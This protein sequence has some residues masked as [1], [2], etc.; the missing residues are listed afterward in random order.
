MNENE[1]NSLQNEIN[2]IKDTLNLVIK[3]IEK[4]TVTC[5]RMDEHIS[6]VESIYNTLKAPIDYITRVFRNKRII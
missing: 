1:L 4:L 2:E 6:F 5:S 3:S